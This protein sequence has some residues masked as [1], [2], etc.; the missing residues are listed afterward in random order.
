MT[1]IP[2][3]SVADLASQRSTIQLVDVRNPDE[4]DVAHVPGAR[5]IPLADL[6]ERLDDVPSGTVHFICRSGQRSLKACEFL[7]AQGRDVVNIDGG[8]LAWIDAGHAVDAGTG[9][10]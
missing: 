2:H 4:Y 1:D 8:T 3:L 5:L 10:S 7:A 6:P 9:E